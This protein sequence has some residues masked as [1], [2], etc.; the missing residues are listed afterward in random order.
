MLTRQQINEA[1]E[2]LHGIIRHTELIHSSFYSKSLGTPIYFKCE[3]LQHSGSFKIRGAYNF[4]SRQTPE[5]LSV[6]VITASTGNHALGLSSAAEQLHCPCRIIMPKGTPLT[7]ELAILESGGSVEL[8][9]NNCSE[10]ESYAK[11]LAEKDPLPQ[12]PYT[13]YY[14]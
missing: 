10:T 6:G 9:G 14:R 1:A 4:L 8:Y 3:N 11:Q 7:K 2:N 12:C 5:T 13:Q